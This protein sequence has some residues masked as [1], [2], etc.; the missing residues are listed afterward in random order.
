MK[1]EASR[2]LYRRLAPYGVNPFTVVESIR[3]RPRYRADRAEF[4]QQLSTAPDASSWPMGRDYPCLRDHLGS[5]GEA[6][7][8]YFHQDLWVARLIFEAQPRRHVDVGSR[9]D[10]FVAHVASF[11]SIDVFDIRPLAVSVPGVTFR[12]L[13]ITANSD[14]FNSCCDSLS[15]LHAL[16]HFGLGRYGDRVDVSGWRRGWERLVQMVE[17]GGTLYISV[18]IG[19]QRVEF[20]AHRVFAVPFLTDVFREQCEIVR[21]AYVDDQGNFHPDVNLTR[22]EAL[23]AFGC[24]YGCGIFVLRR[25]A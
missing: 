9:I 8:A 14:E 17:K 19:P 5:A 20:D 7:G 4:I 22:E 21:F 24:T 12:Q 10:G 2:W 1:R 11:R 6:S 16:E 3:G 15:C 25:M 13:D 23:Q 18:P